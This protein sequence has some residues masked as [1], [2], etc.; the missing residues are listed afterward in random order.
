MARINFVVP[1]LSRVKF[2]G[3]IWC[4][5]MYAHGLAGRGHN[6]TIVPMLPSEY[7]DWFPNSIGRMV[8]S[9]SKHRLKKALGS[10]LRA[11]VSVIAER[12]SFRTYLEQA[13]RDVCLY[14]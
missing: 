8:L 13:V 3:G 14:R 5:L 7:P 2:S 11:A 1:P 12:K 4:I 6:V 10:T 9:N